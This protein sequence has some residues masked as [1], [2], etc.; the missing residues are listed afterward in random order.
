MLS[1][2]HTYIHTYIYVALFILEY[3]IPQTLENSRT[4]NFSSCD[5]GAYINVTDVATKS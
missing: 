5:G 1:S 4:I 2:T 3:L